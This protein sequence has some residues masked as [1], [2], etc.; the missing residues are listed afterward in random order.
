MKKIYS[1]TLASIALFG[2]MTAQQ[3]PFNANGARQ[4][5]VLAPNAKLPYAKKANASSVN[6]KVASA[7]FRLQVDAVGDVMFNKGLLL[8]GSASANQDLFLAPLFMDSTVKF[9]YTG[10]DPYISDIMFG[11]VLDPKSS[12]LQPTF[13]SIV[14]PSE[15]YTLDTVF[16]PGSYI[17]VT[18]TVDTLYTWIV[19]GDTVGTPATAQN[20]VF[21]KEPAANLWISPLDTW[22]PNLL[23]PR[24]SGMVGAP[25]NKATAAAPAT[26]R[27]LVKYVLQPDDSVSLSGRFKYIEV[28]LPTAI[29][30]PANNVVAC[31]F[32]FVPGVA[33]AATTSNIYTFTGG[34]VPQNV[35]GFAAIV[36]GQNSPAVAAAADYQDHQN[37]PTGWNMGF[38]YIKEQRHI[39]YNTTYRAFQFGNPV[40]APAIV[41]SIGGPN[42]PVGVTELEKTG[43]ALS[44]NMPN[45]FTKESTVKFTLAKD[46]N[47]A[48]FTVTD[49]MG[50]VV[51]SEK[52]ATTTGTHSVKLGAYAAGVYYYS[53]NVDGVV[54]T[55]KMIVE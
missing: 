30:V 4:K 20:A 47:S 50:R 19:W 39:A 37:D 42:S 11:T 1:L 52:V 8:D 23:G 36:W 2:T 40:Q 41:Y 9:S 34:A 10:A 15:G 29:N 12:L 53:L 21:R 54:T 6:A 18:P 51:T 16:I 43:V 31:F 33:Y 13:T 17:K 3:N 49:I 35:N 46:V 14:T 22:K 32:T 26:N 7:P 55:K 28:K 24:M 25:G 48:L 44:Q 5:A 38:S 27:T 45:P